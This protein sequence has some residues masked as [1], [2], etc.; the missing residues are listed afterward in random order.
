MGL[1]AILS[2][3]ALSGA[4]AEA[5]PG[6]EADAMGMS[7]ILSAVAPSGAQ[8]EAPPGAE[9]DAMGARWF[10]ARK[11]LTDPEAGNTD[12]EAGTRMAASRFEL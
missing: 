7:A 4:E 12:R 8:A 10:G 11:V 3:V 9:A 5:P 6:A 2:A 1:S